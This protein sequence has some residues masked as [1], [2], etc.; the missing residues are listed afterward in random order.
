MNSAA[1]HP[2]GV[3]SSVILTDYRIKGRRRVLK[4]GE[5][6]EMMRVV[7]RK[8]HSSTTDKVECDAM[9]GG[10]PHPVIIGTHQK[11]DRGWCLSWR[12][13]HNRRRDTNGMLDNSH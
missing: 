2:T 4:V 3:L 7:R 9:T 8:Q 6:V 12:C 10:I 13:C 11:R 5:E 1:G